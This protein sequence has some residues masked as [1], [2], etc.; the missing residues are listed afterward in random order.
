MNIPRD[1]LQNNIRSILAIMWSLI[2]A[3]IL[4]KIIDR[5]NLE[6]PLVIS[7]VQALIG[8]GMLYLGYY[9]GSS[10]DKNTTT[11]PTVKNPTSIEETITQTTKSENK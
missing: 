10:K 4:N 3:L 8:I 9:F 6:N 11:P 7:I 5:A 1:W 2:I